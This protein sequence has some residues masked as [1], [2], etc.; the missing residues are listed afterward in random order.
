MGGEDSLTT[1][2]ANDLGDLILLAQAR[3]PRRGP[4]GGRTG[5]RPVGP[6]SSPVEQY[7][8]GGS[9]RAN[10]QF[11]RAHV[12]G[13]HVGRSVSQLQARLAAHPRLDTA[14]SFRTEAEAEAFIAE[15][16]SQAPIPRTNVASGQWL[17]IPDHAG[18]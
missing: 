5:Q 9:L 12:L 2:T 14:S 1:L 16:L 3:P 13:E 15:A 8:P 10:E 17:R 11:P 4:G 6:N 7:V 18:H